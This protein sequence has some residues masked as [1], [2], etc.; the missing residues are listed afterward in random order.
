MSKKIITFYDNQ[1]Q[2]HDFPIVTPDYGV[3]ESPAD[4]V[5]KDVTCS[6][7]YLDTG[8]EI[9]VK[10]INGHTSSAIY[11][12]VNSTGSKAVSFVDGISPS[13]VIK[14]GGCYGFV[15]DGTSWIYKG[16]A[17]SDGNGVG[18]LSEQN[19]EIFNDY[20]T[21]EAIGQYSHAEGSGTKAG[22]VYEFI[23]GD[24]GYCGICAHAEGRDTEAYGDCAH[25]E[26][27][28]TYA[29]HIYSH[30]EGIGTKS[31]GE[32]SHVQGK[33]NYYNPEKDVFAHV[34]GNGTSD[35]DRKNIHTVDWDGNAVYAGTVTTAGIILTS[36]NRTKF[37]ITV[38]DN[39]AL[40]TV[41][42]TDEL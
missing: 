26:G 33:Y 25:A 5:K 1:K 23:N 42:E 15:Y 36:P 41:I 24:V 20:S 31:T 16:V 17:S 30:A 34:I 28:N 32:A 27:N 40:S 35:T 18:K 22:G 2:P 3:C 13:K 14:A 39:G 10:F 9:S 19:G 8:A 12:D 4:N 7:F 6:D 37:K 11:L 21:N 29:T 38:D